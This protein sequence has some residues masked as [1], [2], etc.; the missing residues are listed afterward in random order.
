MV[1]RGTR[2]GRCC[3]R[4][5]DLEAV[6]V[7]AVDAGDLAGEAGVEA[8]EVGAAEEA[9]DRAV[10]GD[11]VDERRGRVGV[12]D[13]PL[14]AG[15][16]PTRWYT[17]RLLS[18]SSTMSGAMLASTPIT[19]SNSSLVRS[20]AFACLWASQATLKSSAKS[21]KSWLEMPRPSWAAFMVLHE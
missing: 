5:V 16:R 14:I 21:P 7:G 4:R 18:A 2:R 19:T 10:L 3:R 1:W 8:D 12:A 17:V 20:G 13:E 6:G 11:V 15:L 9:V